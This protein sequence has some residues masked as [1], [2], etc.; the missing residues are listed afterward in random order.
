M[1]VRVGKRIPY[2]TLKAISD[3]KQLMEFLRESTYALAGQVPKKLK[4]R[5]RRRELVE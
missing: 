3:R 5:R 2:E 1:V 4:R